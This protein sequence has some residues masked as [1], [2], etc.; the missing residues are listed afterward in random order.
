[1]ASSV[2][3]YQNVFADLPV[4]SLTEGL[5]LLSAMAAVAIRLIR[6]KGVLDVLIAE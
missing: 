6:L 2:W 4:D 5:E 3:K 1:M